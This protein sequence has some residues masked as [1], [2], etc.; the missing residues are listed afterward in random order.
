MVGEP[1][2][3]EMTIISSKKLPQFLS[4][5]KNMKTKNMGKI[6]LN[7]PK[8]IFKKMCSKKPAFVL[9]QIHS[10]FPPPQI[11]RISQGEN[12]NGECRIRKNGT[13]PTRDTKKY[14]KVPKPPEIHRYSIFLH[15][16]L[17][18]SACCFSRAICAA[19]SVTSPC[20]IW[21]LIGY[22][23]HSCLKRRS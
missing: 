2:P 10:D 13:Y 9:K 17:S 21:I 19:S 18:L 7:L 12:I 20:D 1:Q 15:S 3:T 5:T 23:Q 4:F 22:Q 14:I 8:S 16:R 6:P 11:C